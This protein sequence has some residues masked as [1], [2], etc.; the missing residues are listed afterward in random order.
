MMPALPGA[1]LVLIHARLTLASLEARFNAG[2]RLDHAC[3]FSKRRFLEG[4][5]GPSCRREIILV[6]VA[7]VLLGGIPRGTGLQGPVV[8]QGTTGDHQ[9]LVGSGPFALDPRLHAAC[10]HLDDYRA[11][12]PVSH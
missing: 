8:R 11:F 5:R 10:D 9:P 1:Y 4:D 12:L 7:G 6:A 3:Q 2:A